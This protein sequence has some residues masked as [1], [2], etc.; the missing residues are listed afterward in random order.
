M[1]AVAAEERE[2]EREDKLRKRL[3]NIYTQL[4][5][6]TESIIEEC[7]IYIQYKKQDIRQTPK[8]PQDIK[9]KRNAQARRLAALANQ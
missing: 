5:R 6:K 9:H 3:G 7:D 1:W 4:A 2:R 8:Q